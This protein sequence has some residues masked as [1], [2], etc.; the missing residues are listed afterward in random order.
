MFIHE[1]SER[2][3]KRLGRLFTRFAQYRR[4]S[5]GGLHFLE[6]GCNAQRHSPDVLDETEPEHC[7]Y[8][9]QFAHSKCGDGLILAH[10]QRDVVE[11]QMAL[12]VRDQL[13]C[14]LVRARISR[15]RAGRE[16]GELLVVTLWK[17]CPD[18]AD[19]LLNDVEVVQKP[20]AGRTDVESTLGPM[21]ELLVNSIENCFRVVEA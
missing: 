5:V 2:H 15:E 1:R 19:V 3:C 7:G 20:V 11:V 17:I 16:F 21:I 18:L 6:T 4:G 12:G 10:E 9:P 14:Y 8:R 13:D